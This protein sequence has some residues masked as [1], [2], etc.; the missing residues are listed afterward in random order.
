MVSITKGEMI[1]QPSCKE[2]G[3]C[4]LGH[5]E[6]F[7]LFRFSFLVLLFLGDGWQG[8]QGG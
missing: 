6:L 4:F 3:P 8:G 5:Q 2:S 1:S 7:P